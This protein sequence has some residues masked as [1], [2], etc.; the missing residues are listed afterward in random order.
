MKYR[1]CIQ[2][3][4]STVVEVEADSEDDAIF[5]ALEEAPQNDFAHADYDAG[6]WYVDEDT[7]YPAVVPIGDSE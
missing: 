4:G 1:V 2:F 3:V 6:E 7:S 5:Q